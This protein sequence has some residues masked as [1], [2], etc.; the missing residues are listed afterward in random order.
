MQF[1]VYNEFEIKMFSCVDD[2]IRNDVEI[3]FMNV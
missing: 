3:I 1:Q 2:L